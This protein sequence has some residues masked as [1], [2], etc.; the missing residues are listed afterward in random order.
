M[1]G[2]AVIVGASLVS[3]INFNI[4]LLLGFITSFSLTAA[5]MAI[6]DYYDRDIDVIN[7]PKRPIPS[8][9]I[10]IKEAL[11]FSCILT[12]IGL[13]CAIVT[14][15]LS[16]FTG[17]IAWLVCMIYSTIGKRKGFYGNLLVSTCVTIP[18]IYGSIV[19]KNSIEVNSILFAALIFFANTGREVAKG[20]VDV[21]GD[22]QKKVKTV[23]VVHGEK[24]AAIVAV[25]FLFMAVALSPVPWTLGLVSPWFIPFVIITDVGLIK[26]SIS[27][28][29]DSSR[30]NARKVKN[31]ML[32]WFILG[33]VAF[34]AG[35][36]K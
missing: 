32:I 20:I 36:L 28:L 27:L 24:K 10:T 30:E 2:F 16:F 4:N 7:E 6:N 19:I 12:T 34:L 21:K 15:I 35:N 17:L 1:M 8:G 5:S 14:S 18:I 22:T 3:T 13:G 23:A 11:I 26:C 29:K 25:S 9:I 33:L 31:Q